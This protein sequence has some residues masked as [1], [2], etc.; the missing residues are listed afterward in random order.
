MMV[1]QSGWCTGVGL[2]E[3]PILVMNSW[4]DFGGPD[5]V[6]TVC[7]QSMDNGVV[8]FNTLAVGEG[9]LLQDMGRAL[10]SSAARAVGMIFGPD[11]G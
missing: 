4:L 9:T 5:L 11:G 10:H 8:S 3:L 6:A 1:V 7:C 2:I